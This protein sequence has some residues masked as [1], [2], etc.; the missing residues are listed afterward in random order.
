[1]K[2]IFTFRRL[3]FAVGAV[4]LV[5]AVVLGTNFGSRPVGAQMTTKDVV[6]FH[7]SVI[8][9]Q[10]DNFALG[11]SHYSQSA[12]AP[13]VNPSSCAQVMADLLNAGFRLKSALVLP[14]G[15]PGSTGATEYV[16]VR[17]ANE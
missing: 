17:G 1:M 13:N 7:C 15:G 8:A 3:L 10:P 16:F 6:I 11:F 9:N 2:R 12:N 5:G 4:A 14:N